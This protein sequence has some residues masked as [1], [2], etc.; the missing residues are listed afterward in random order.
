MPLKREFGSII[1]EVPSNQL[2]ISGGKVNTK[3]T[4]TKTKSLKSVNNKKS[5]ELRP[6]KGNKIK[7]IN[8]GK[9]VEPKVEKEKALDRKMRSKEISD[10]LLDKKINEILIK[11]PKYKA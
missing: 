7:I 11:I 6:I 10:T 2:F 8:E 9:L 4:L 3:P 1:I 5:L